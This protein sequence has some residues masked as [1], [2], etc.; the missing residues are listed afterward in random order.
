MKKNAN[1]EYEE[2]EINRTQEMQLVGQGGVI[3]EAGPQPGYENYG[4]Q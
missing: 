1:V 3:I 2:R 4:Y